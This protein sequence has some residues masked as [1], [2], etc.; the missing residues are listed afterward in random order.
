MVEL[1]SEEFLKSSFACQNK[2]RLRFA[3][4]FYI[5]S[6]NAAFSPWRENRLLFSLHEE[7]I[8]VE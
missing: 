5:A 3:F 7:K 4:E 2:S 6:K 1:I 8:A